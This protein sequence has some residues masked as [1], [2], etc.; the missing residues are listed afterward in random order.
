LFGFIFCQNRE[1]STNPDAE[2][3][4]YPRKFAKLIDLRRVHGAKNVNFVTSAPHV[5]AVLKIV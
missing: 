2:Y 1:I 4:I 3:L 5:H